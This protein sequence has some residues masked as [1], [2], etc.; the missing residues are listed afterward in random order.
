MVEDTRAYP[1]R[2]AS[3]GHVDERAP[4]VALGRLVGGHHRGHA[5]AEPRSPGR[6][7][8]EQGSRIELARGDPGRGGRRR[9]DGGRRRSGR[10]QPATRQRHRA[11]QRQP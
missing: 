5:G 7:V 10:E 8:T 9:V 1:S 2:H 6:Q 3:F 11:E 4:P